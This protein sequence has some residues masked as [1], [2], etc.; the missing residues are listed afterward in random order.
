MDQLLQRAWQLF[1]WQQPEHLSLLA[2]GG[3]GRGELHPHSDIDLLLLVRNDKV[4]AANH[5][6]LSGFFTF[7]WD[8]N[9]EIGQSVRTIEECR[10]EAL[11]DITVA[12]SLMESRTV[13]GYHAESAACDEE[14]LRQ[15]MIAITQADDVWPARAFFRAKR[16]EQVARHKK[17]QDID[18]ALEPN[19]K[20][21]PG[22]L[23]D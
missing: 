14:S 23:R 9:L 4:R 7:L 19:V 3:Y 13:V 17:Y 16:D 20:T 6:A 21:S 5:N 15:E 8:V 1:D 2:V 11:K 12:T 18:Y 22:G 10:T